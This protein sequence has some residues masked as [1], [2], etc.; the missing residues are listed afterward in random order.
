M[1]QCLLYDLHQGFQSIII[2]EI[3]TK[4]AYL[5]TYRN[6]KAYDAKLA[7]S[8]DVVSGLLE[9]R[10]SK[11]SVSARSREFSSLGSTQKCKISAR[12]G[13]E[14]SSLDYITA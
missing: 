14:N 3:Y 4:P 11:V 10:F 7:K 12:L 9:T 1:S 5:N 8:S 6:G 2:K 13:L